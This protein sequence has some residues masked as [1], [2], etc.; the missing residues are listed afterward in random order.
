MIKKNKLN[1]FLYLAISIICVVP[2]SFIAVFFDVEFTD[3]GFLSGLAYRVSLGQE[4]YKDIDYIRPPLSPLLWS[5]IIGIVPHE[6]G[7]VFIRFFVLVQKIVCSA[8]IGTI[9][10]RVKRSEIDG[11][12][13]FILSLVFLIHNL[14]H[15]IWYT[16]DGLFFLSI[17]IFLFYFKKYELGFFAALIAVLAKQSFVFFP[18]LFLMC[19]LF[20]NRKI[21]LRLFFVLMLFIYL[22]WNTF[23]LKLFFDLSIDSMSVADLFRVSVYPHFLLNIFDI[24]LLLLLIAALYFKN[25]PATTLIIGMIFCSPVINVMLRSLS[26]YFTSGYFQFFGPQVGDTHHW[27]FAY[28]IFALWRSKDLGVSSLGDHKFIVTIL[29]CAAAWSSTISWGYNNYLF[30]A[31]LIFCAILML[32]DCR[33]QID[34]RLLFCFALAISIT[35]SALRLVGPYR[36]DGIFDSQKSLI[37]SGYFKHIYVSEVE[38]KRLSELNDNIEEISEQRCIILYPSMPQFYLF[39]KRE[40]FLRLDWKIDV[41]YPSKGLEYQSI[42]DNK[43]ILILENDDGNL[44]WSA[45]GQKST[46]VPLKDL[47]NCKSKIKEHLKIYNMSACVE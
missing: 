12:L 4:L 45:K 23:D 33:K 38:L 39:S 9:A 36:T 40:P 10:F 19:I 5:I 8:L 2:L 21:F 14:T 18:I 34:V 31:G 30:S 42:V 27:I 26:F 17:S 7:E 46:L 15:M 3:S 16:V 20:L 43:C 28:L 29:L 44:G 32:D 11:L 35:F 47:K 41:E 37:T 24:V 6:G 25:T 1:Y 22:S 13:V